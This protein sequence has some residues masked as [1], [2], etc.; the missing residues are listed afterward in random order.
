MTSKDVTRRTVMRGAAA[1]FAAAGVR[2]PR[3]AFAQAG[4]VPEKIFRG[5]TIVTLDESRPEVE[6]I[7]MGQGRILALGTEAEVMAL[8]TDA[9]EIYDLRGATLMPSFIDPHGH[10]MNAPQMVR[11]ANVSGVPAGPITSIADILTELKAHVA[12][13]DLMPGEWIIGYGYDVTT[14]SDGRELS[15]DDLDPVFPDNPILLLHVS[16]HG[17][18]L[19]SAGFDFFGMDETTETPVGGLILR[20]E[21]TNRPDGLI[22][23]QAFAPVFAALPKPSVED[24]LSDMEAAQHFY[25]SAGVTTASEGGTHAGDLMFLLNAADRGLLKIDVVS[26]PFVMEIPMLVAEFAPSFVPDG[27][28]LPDTA[29]EVFD[30]YR[31][32]LKLG[33][34]KIPLD[35]SPQGK[36]AFWTEPL[37]TPGPAGEEGWTGIPLFPPEA[38]NAAVAE[39][40]GKGIQ[41]FMH[42]N[43]DAAIDMAVDAV[44]A[45]GL[46]SEDDH[47]TTI[48]HS[49]FMRPDHLDAYAELG[50]TPSYF[51]LHTFF[52]GDVHVENTGEARAGFISPMAS[53][54][55]R[56][57][58]MT[59]HTDFSVCPM[60]PMRVMHSAITRRSRTGRVIGPDE[61][62][63]ALTALRAMTIDAA[64]QIREEDLK[65]TL[66]VGKLADLVVLD[67]NPLSVPTDDLLSIAV[68][69]TFKE[70]TSV[71]RAGA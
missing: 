40:A 58:R 21:G 39:F 1:L 38:V 44:R 22:M 2:A 69:E 9:T 63:D 54:R 61:R 64:W 71:Y 26:L 17:C 70:G 15:R 37:L 49:Q 7:A 31:N 32:H 16:N 50:M 8:A 62:V 48:V 65:G 56:G 24:L 28:K 30:K 25:T 19:N 10:F 45:A 18:V 55:A 52:W 36:T 57:I 59:N 42:A 51:T 46:T 53:T 4:T 47:R 14:L 5:G 66:E 13:W 41:V 3:Q 20:Q 6:A 12:K 34:I 67:A 11:W 68:V 33:G 23:E 27:M 43:G 29:G 35:G 60:E